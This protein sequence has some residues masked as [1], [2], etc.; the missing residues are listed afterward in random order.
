MKFKRGFYVL[1]FGLFTF[2][3]SVSYSVA[4]LKF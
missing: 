1:D 2:L 3:F 4:E